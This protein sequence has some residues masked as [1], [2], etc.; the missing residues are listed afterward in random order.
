M[1][2]RRPSMVVVAGP[3][4][5]GKTTLTRRLLRHPWLHEHDFVN[6]DEIAQQELGDWNSWDAVRAAAVLADE[7]RE[8]SL[9]A[10]RDFAYETVFSTA[11]R[12]A[13]IE[14]AVAAG[15]FIRLYFVGTS[16]PAVNVRRVA[17]RV[18]EG[19]HDVPSDKIVARYHRSMANLTQALPITDRAYVFDNSTDNAPPVRWV[20]TK[21][22]ALVKVT[23]G[24]MPEWI[25]DAITAP[26]RD[27][28]FP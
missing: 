5:S 8:A 11:E 19:G 12:V 2:T 27:A 25:Q 26:R 10:R 9:L 21:S 17:A 6:A 1:T 13:F 7:R 23:G 15:Y 14:R 4:G 3:N 22:G 16:N 24:A 28:T 18:A 20:R